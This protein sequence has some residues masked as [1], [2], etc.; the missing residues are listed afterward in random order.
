[1]TALNYFQLF[2]LAI[3]IIAVCYMGSSLIQD[4]IE[5][6]KRK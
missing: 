2:G 1:M 3:Q 5:R 4:H 6:K